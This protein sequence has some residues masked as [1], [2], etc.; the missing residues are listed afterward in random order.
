VSALNHAE[1]SKDTRFVSFDLKGS[2]VSYHA[3]DALGIFPENCPDTVQWLLEALDGNGTETVS[4][5]DGSNASFHEALLRHYQVTKPTEALIEL[6]MRSASDPTHAAELKAMLADD[7]P[8]IPEGCE[9]LDVLAQFPSARPSIEDFAQALSPLSPRLYSI[10]SSP[11]M[12]PDEVHLT[13]GVVRFVN[14][15]GRQCKGVAS[16]YLAE[17]LRSGQKVRMFVQHSHFRPPTDGSTPMIMVGPGT[18]IAPFRAFLQDR[19]ADKSTGQNWLFF[20]DQR[21]DSDFLYREELETWRR[22]GLLTKLDTAFSRDQTEK[23]YVQHRMIQSG[24]EIWDWLQQGAHFYVCGDAK[25]MA[26]DVDTALKQI[27]ADHGKMSPEAAKA[28]VA[29]M[30]KAK[31]YQR[32]VY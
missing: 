12:N 20:G 10:S 19:A 24:R 32:D 16:T 23:V 9:V 14:N 2:G 26:H 28:Y 17:R 6:L 25:R 27:I 7:G 4:L 21:A 5:P 1:S 15:R 22:D 3:G 11:K 30:S 31:R 8:G 18:G 29:E 13:V